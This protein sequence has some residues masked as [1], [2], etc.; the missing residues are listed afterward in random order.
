MVNEELLTYNVYSTERIYRDETLC[1]FYFKPNRKIIKNFSPID[2]DGERLKLNLQT[3]EITEYKKKDILNSYNASLR[4]T[5]ILMNMLLSMNDFDWFWTLTFDKQKIDR[6]N[7]QAVFNCYE[8]YINN[9]KKQFPCFKY[10]T[11]PERHEDGC[12]HFH[13]LTAGLTPSQMGLVNSGK[14]CCSW[15]KKKYNGVVSRSYYERTKHL[16][17]HKDTDGEP[18]YNA[19]SFVYGFTTVS[20]IVSRERCNSYVKKYVEKALGSTEVFK[21]RFYYSANL[22]V[23]YLVKKYIG[24]EFE[25]PTAIEELSCIKNNPYIQNAKG[26]YVNDYNVLQVKIDND[27]KQFLDKGLVPLSDEE[28]FNL[29]FKGEILD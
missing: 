27:M 17:E 15:A 10:M 18:I 1:S 29:Y 20:R 13:L 4:R 26:V 14:V 8:K 21:K 2:I 23:P 16:F 6:T 7:A 24:T 22:N 5:T 28:I 3:G 11:F 25:I 19:T 12:F 9:I